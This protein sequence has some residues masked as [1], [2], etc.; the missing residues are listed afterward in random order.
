MCF[1]AFAV[2]IKPFFMIVDCQISVKTQ[3]ILPK[4]S[5]ILQSTIFFKNKLSL[6]TINNEGLKLSV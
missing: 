3:K 1:I 4:K 5:F 6:I 2:Q